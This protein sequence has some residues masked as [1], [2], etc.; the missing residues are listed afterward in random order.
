MDKIDRALYGAGVKHCPV[1]V[2]G[3]KKNGS[4]HTWVIDGIKIKS[5]LNEYH[6]NW[7]W[8]GSSD[9]WANA[10]LI[11]TVGG[12]GSTI[13]YYLSKCAIYISDY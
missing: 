2:S 6:Q 12:E 9:G 11:T 7:G 4:G 5:P 8:G 10:S 13:D 3:F 1:I